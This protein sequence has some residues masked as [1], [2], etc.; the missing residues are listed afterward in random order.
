M[1]ACATKRQVSYVVVEFIFRGSKCNFLESIAGFLG[2]E[3]SCSSETGQN[4]LCLS[5]W[6]VMI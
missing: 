4:M 1:K 5:L 2:H 6:I 3:P